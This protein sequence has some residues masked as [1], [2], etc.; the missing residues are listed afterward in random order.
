[1][2]KAFRTWAWSLGVVARSYW[3]LL[4]LAALIALWA[5]A[6]YEWLGLP[7]S[8]GLLLILALVWAIA[9]VLAAAGI[10]AGNVAGAE[11]VVTAGGRKLPLSSLWSSDRRKFL[12]ALI[13]CFVTCFLVWLLAAFFDWIN[14]H[15]IDVASFL[16]FHLQKPVSHVPIEKIYGIIETLLWIVLGGF[17]FSFLHILL[18][19]GWR[20]AGKELW[21]ILA[22]AIFRTPFFTTLLSVGVFGTLAYQLA[23]WRPR[24]P[25]G[26]WDYAQ[27][28]VRLAIVL[29]LLATGWLFWSLSLAR[30]LL[31]A[32]EGQEGAAQP[33]AGAVP[34]EP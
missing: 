29:I 23:N 20:E 32:G 24:A 2:K 5:F 3:T 10:V 19:G 11:A 13:F 15:S 21:K 34:A 7:E 33:P 27:M 22:G 17:L 12:N 6:A 16:T 9:Q 8:S 18:R 30:T 14:N 4:A 25:V 28:I 1:M 31:P 26:F